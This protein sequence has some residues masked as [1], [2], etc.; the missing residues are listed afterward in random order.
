MKKIAPEMAEYGLEG[1]PDFYRGLLRYPGYCSSIQAM[2]DLG[3][4]LVLR[5]T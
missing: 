1:I 5:V 4:L 3:F 2:K